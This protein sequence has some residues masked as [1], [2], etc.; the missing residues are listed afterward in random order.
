MNSKRSFKMVIDENVS[1]VL[2][3]TTRKARVTIKLHFKRAVQFRPVWT[4][5][6]CSYFHLRC[7][8]SKYW[9]LDKKCDPVWF[10]ITSNHK[11]RGSP[12]YHS[13]SLSMNILS[14]PGRRVEKSRKKLSRKVQFS[15]TKDL[16]AVRSPC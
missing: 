16:L 7:I 11:R 10:P 15:Q 8:Y 13:C 12:F 5:A 6:S 1:W 2:F 9:R 4:S 3:H 14:H